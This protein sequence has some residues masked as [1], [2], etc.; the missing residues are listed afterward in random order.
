M[1]QVKHMMQLAW[2]I[3]AVQSDNGLGAAGRA[4]DDERESRGRI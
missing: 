1:S 3:F 2:T 4:R